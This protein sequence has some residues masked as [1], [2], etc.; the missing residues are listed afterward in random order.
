MVVSERAVS[1]LSQGQ[2][3]RLCLMALEI[4]GPRVLLLDEPFASLDLPTQ[5]ALRNRLA[6]ADRQ[7]LLS[8]H[9][10]AWLGDFERVIWLESGRVKQDGAGAAVCAAYSADVAGRSAPAQPVS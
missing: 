6:S 7:I 5:A 2:R 4:A 8:T 3:Q 9:Q 1:A 10:L